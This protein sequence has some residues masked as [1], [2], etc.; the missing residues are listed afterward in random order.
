MKANIGNAPGIAAFVGSAGQVITGPIQE[1]LFI[2]G[3]SFSYED[4]H[5]FDVDEVK[6]FVFDP[7]LYAGPQLVFSPLVFA[8]SSGPIL[9]QYYANFLGSADGTLLEASNRRF[10]FDGPLS[11]IR[12]NPTPT[13]PGAYGT[14]FAGDMVPATGNNPATSTGAGNS[15]GL[16][17]EPSPTLKTAFTLTNT[18]GA[19]TYVQIKMTWFEV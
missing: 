8:A 17:F 7:A 2:E 4:Y 1:Q 5:V 12:L 3:K 16:P 11:T 10:G 15:A 6:L 13:V 14:R 18:D 9:V 19:A